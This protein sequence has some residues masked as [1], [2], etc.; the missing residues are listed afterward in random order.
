MHLFVICYLL[1][2]DGETIAS[3]NHQTPKSL[4]GNNYSFRPYFK[5]AILGHPTIYL[6]LGI[7]THKRGF[8]FSSPVKNQ[9][10]KKRPKKQR[11]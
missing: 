1:A 10:G 7:T 4:I 5:K 6:A 11:N 8:Y 3:S 9:Y 2:P